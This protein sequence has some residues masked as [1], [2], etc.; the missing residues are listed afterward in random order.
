[1][2]GVTLKATQMKTVRGNYPKAACN[3]KLEGSAIY[4]VVVNSNGQ[5][6]KPPFITQSSGYGLLNNQGLQQVRAL[7]FPQST[8]VKVIFRYDSKICGTGVV[9]KDTNTQTQ[10]SPIPE[11]PQNQAPSV[12]TEPKSPC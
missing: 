6:S 1:M 10:A 2:G 9:E 5:L 4:N 7:S 8:R 3:L 11:T 12:P